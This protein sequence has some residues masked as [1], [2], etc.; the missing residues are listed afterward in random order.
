MPQK[1]LEKYLWLNSNFFE[2]S[3][4]KHFDDDSLFVKTF[5]VTSGVTNRSQSYWGDIISVEVNY[6]NSSNE[7]K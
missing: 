5:D 6:T 7:L 4:R 1:I 3:L 2:E